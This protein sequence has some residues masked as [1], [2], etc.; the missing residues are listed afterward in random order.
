MRPNEG[1]ALDP[2]AQQC[3][4]ARTRRP[5]RHDHPEPAQNAQCHDP[6]QNADVFYV[7][8]GTS[9]DP[10]LTPLDAEKLASEAATL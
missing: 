6:T 7:S 4:A 1:V 10:E 3:G 9:G 8:K 5:Y 2:D